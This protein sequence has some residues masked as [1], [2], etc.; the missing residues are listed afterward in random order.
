MFKLPSGSKAKL[1]KNLILPTSPQWLALSFKHGLSAG[2]HI[3]GMV[4]TYSYITALIM[5]TGMVPET[6]VIFNQLTQ[7]I[8]WEDFINV[9]CHENFRSYKTV[10]Y[11]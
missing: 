4:W 7:L 8:A 6:L 1:S 2:I 11:S 9:S 3:C 5:G 10:N